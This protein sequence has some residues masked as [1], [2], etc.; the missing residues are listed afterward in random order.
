MCCLEIGSSV[1]RLV[2]AALSTCKHFT[3]TTLI[4][5]GR[6]GI[7]NRSQ[8]QWHYLVEIARPQPGLYSTGWTRRK[9]RRSSP[10][11]LPQGIEYQ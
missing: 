5:F 11:C 1:H 10:L 7:A 3:D 4:Q 8:Q 2:E 9:A 6:V